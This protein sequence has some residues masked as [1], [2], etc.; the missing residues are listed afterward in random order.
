MVQN[1]FPRERN[2]L[3][4]EEVAKQLKFLEAELHLFAVDRDL[5][6][7]L[8]EA[9]TGRF[10]LLVARPRGGALQNRVDSREQY[11]RA[12]GFCNILICAERKAL[13]LILLFGARGQHEH[14]HIRDVPKF[15]QSLKTV[16]LRHHDIEENQRDVR[17]PLEYFERLSAVFRLQHLEALHPEIIADQRAHARLIVRN[18]NFSVLAAHALFS[19]KQRDSSSICF[20]STTSGAF[21]M[22][23]EASLTFGK[24]MT[25]RMVSA[26]AISIARR[27]RP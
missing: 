19:R 21:I 8:V 9:D 6:G 16:H 14:R 4:L 13:E 10:K 24:A 2:A 11:L 27:S 15:F 25:S 5:M 7:A 3:I 26:P 20:S 23:S 22:R 18:Q 12:E 17:F 1:L